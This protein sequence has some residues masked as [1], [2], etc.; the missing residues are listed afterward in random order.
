MVLLPF[1]RIQYH[2]IVR[3]SPDHGTAFDIAGTS[4]ADPGSM[5]E[6]IGLA[7]RLASRAMTPDSVQPPVTIPES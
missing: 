7:C 2:C 5:Q 3:T 4:E 1:L 6:A